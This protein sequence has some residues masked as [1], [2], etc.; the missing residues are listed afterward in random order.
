[1]AY[2]CVLLVILL[3]AATQMNSVH[4]TILTASPET[5][6]S[7]VTANLTLKC[8]PGE[9]IGVVSNIAVFQLSKS[10][11]LLATGKPTEVILGDGLRTNKYSAA[12]QIDPNN[13]NNSFLLFTILFPEEEDEGTYKCDM[14]YEDKQHFLK[15]AECEFN[16]AQNAS[17]GISVQKRVDQTLQQVE[18]LM[19]R[20]NKLETQVFTL[21][22][23][24]NNQSQTINELSSKA[25]SHV[26]FFVTLSDKLTIHEKDVVQFD[27]VKLN[28]GSAY[29]DTSGVFVAP[30]SGFHVLNLVCEIHCDAS[31]RM[32]MM[33]Q[34]NGTT[35]IKLFV[36]GADV[37]RG[38]QQSG[39]LVYDIPKG[40]EVKVVVGQIQTDSDATVQLIGD[41]LSYFSGYFLG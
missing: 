32:E 21:V 14:N 30:R 36:S 23:E 15:H 37:A 10:G 38:S 34:V 9:T 29:N 12:Q 6:V 28:N 27:S 3:A 20:I 4:T 17:D 8:S 22:T 18:N 16:L 33:L 25:S 26:G 11:K 35:I 1:M 7:G 19:T 2:R 39:S 13:L 24:N 5:Y 31:I 41:S 40:S